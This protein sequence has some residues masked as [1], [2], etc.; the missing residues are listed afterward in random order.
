MKQQGLIEDW[1]DCD[2]SPGSD[3]ERVIDVQLHSSHIILLLVS[4]DFLRSEY[5]GGGEMKKAMKRHHAGEAYIIPIILRPVDWEGLLF[6]KLQ[7]L[8]LG[9]K[10]VTLWQNRD[11]AFL[12]IARGIK[13][14]VNEL[15][16][17][18]LVESPTSV[19]TQGIDLHKLPLVWSVPYRRNPF[20]TAREDILSNLHRLF[21]EQ[22][23]VEVHAQAI[24]GLGGVGKSQVATEYCYRHA[25][26]YNALLWVKADLYENITADF[27]QIAKSVLNIL[28]SGK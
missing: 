1:N 5:S 18:F 13:K 24:S 12:N 26:D 9:A 3:W 23:S 27:V 20:F 15:T 8:P 6:G 7:P 14:V 17:K 25:L 10:A 19:D 2:I 21:E 28:S 22:G 4:A 11:D 16:T